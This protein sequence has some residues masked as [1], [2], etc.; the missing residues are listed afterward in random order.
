LHRRR[1]ASCRLSPCHPSPHP[2][3]ISNGRHRLNTRAKFVGD[4]AATVTVHR[5]GERQADNEPAPAGR[6]DGPLQDAGA[7][8]TI[9]KPDRLSRDAHFL[10]GLKSA[11]I[12][13]RAADMPD[14]DDVMF[15]IMAI[16]AQWER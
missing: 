6:R 7:T 1:Q 4:A 11:G 3:S 10:L 13:V 8:L 9:A 16:L 12:K 5:D 2:P 14:A 15:G